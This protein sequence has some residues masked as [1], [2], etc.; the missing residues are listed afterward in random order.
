MKKRYA[1]YY[2]TDG[3][4]M[5]MLKWAKAFEKN[6]WQI[7]TVLWRGTIVVSTVWLGIDHSFGMGKPLIFESMVFCKLCDG[8]EADMERYSS[9][10]SAQRHHSILVKKWRN[11]FQLMWH[12]INTHILHRQVY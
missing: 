4:P 8:L 1:M 7:R 5:T 9:K 12:I 3:K 10:R 11:P 2:N 6:R